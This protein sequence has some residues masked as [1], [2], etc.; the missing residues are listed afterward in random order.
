MKD[1][2]TIYTHAISDKLTISG[3]LLFVGVISTISLT[4]G[5]YSWEIYMMPIIMGIACSVGAY[6]IFRGRIE[7][8]EERGVLK[9]Y[10]F[11]TRIIPV[12]E[13]K[14]VQRESVPSVKGTVF[15]VFKIVC[16]GNVVH[17][18]RMEEP[19]K[20]GKRWQYVNDVYKQL[21]RRII[22]AQKDR[23]NEK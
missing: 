6:R 16:G 17:E 3:V 21:N 7:L 18:I 23:R 12:E 19:A 10:D 14:M 13:I 22:L 1:K 2:M 20:D 15:Y 5:E 4:A 11:R 9:L 8:D